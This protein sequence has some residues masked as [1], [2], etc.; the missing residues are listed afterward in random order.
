MKKEEERFLEVFITPSELGPNLIEIILLKLK[1][2]YKNK[3]IQRKMIT[4]LKSKN[5]INMPLCRTT[6]SNINVI[7]PEKVF[8][9]I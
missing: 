4:N 1:E 7:V 5:F 9:K 3:D 6:S 8:S 2:K